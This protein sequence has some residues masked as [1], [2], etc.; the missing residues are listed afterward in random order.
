L[1]LDDTGCGRTLQ[2]EFAAQKGELEKKMEKLEKDHEM[3]AS[4]AAARHTE[5]TTELEKIEAARTK[6]K[7]DME[8][9]IREHEVSSTGEWHK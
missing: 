6:L 7:E 2:R 4:K 9:K 3:S 1:N 5:L 8:K